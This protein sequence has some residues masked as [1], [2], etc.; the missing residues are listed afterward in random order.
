MNK[1]I[2]SSR[3]CVGK[4]EL[5]EVEKVFNSGW[6]GMGPVV[7]E[8]ENALKAFLGAR[9]VVAVNSCTSAIHIALDA[10]GIKA[11]DEV[12]VPSLTFVGSIQPIVACGAKPA[13][14]EINADTLTIDTKD[15]KR[16]ITKR[17]KAV[18]PVHYGGQPCDMD[19]L[20]EI[21]GENSLHVIEDAAHAFGSFYNGKKIGSFGEAA[22][23]SFDP[24]KSITC[25]EGGA[26]AAYDGRLAELLRK[27]RILGIDTDSYNRIKNKKGWFYKVVSSGFRYHMSDINAA[28][29]LAQLKQVNK[30]INWRRM[31]CRQYDD[32]FCRIGGIEL[33]KRDYRHINPFYYV[34]K[35]K[36]K[37]RDSL[38]SYLNKSGIG[39]SVHYIP[40]HL[41]PF[42]RKFYR[43]L[44]TT[45]NVFKQILTLPL[46]F[47]LADS[48]VARVIKTVESF[49]TG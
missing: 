47:E 27:K 31:I 22:C 18:M 38:L 21:A 9:H 39:A 12:I 49:F 17:T 34:I 10:L 16:K 35:I 45:E 37:K 29:G 15:V 1:I 26:I 6:L 20:S 42:F 23:F 33:L 44:R 30:F 3:P 5:K 13:F 24:I 19:K 46:Y 40:N 28:I 25:G 2:P 36:A 41:Q 43:P 4:K 14:C 11:G 48:D 7:S 8:F 32:A